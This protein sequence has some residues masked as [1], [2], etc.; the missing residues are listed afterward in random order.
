MAAEMNDLKPITHA[1]M[2]EFI[3]RYPD[4]AP[5]LN[6]RLIMIAETAPLDRAADDLN[7]A[8]ELFKITFSEACRSLAARIRAAG[9]TFV[10]PRMVN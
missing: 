6:N 5:G 10:D 9:D 2:E 8:A 1:T 7:H 3:R 4:F